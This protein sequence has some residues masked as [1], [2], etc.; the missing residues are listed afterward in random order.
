VLTGLWT[1]GIK[2]PDLERELAFHRSM[3]NAV[4]LNDTIEFEG[5]SYRIPLI[6]MG[7][8]YVH[9]AE[10]MVYERLLDQ[11]LPYGI[12]HLVYMSDD[13]ERDLKI[14]LD[15]GARAF[16]DLSTISAGFGK[17]KVAFLRA[18]SGYIFE[19]IQ[20]LENLVPPV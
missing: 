4:V 17:R 12:V 13:I 16:I 9:I 20:I 2:V 3:G 15:S 18:P 6:K 14:A 8:K 1:V 5:R 7:D 11:P 10:A 19:I